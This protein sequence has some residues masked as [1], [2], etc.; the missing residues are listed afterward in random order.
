MI[1]SGYR[2]YINT[3]HANFLAPSTAS[4]EPVG[5]TFNTLDAALIAGCASYGISKYLIT[6]HAAPIVVPR[7]HA[8]SG[9]V[10]P[11]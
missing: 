7:A 2:V 5:P 1:N 11:C 8:P 9:G 10:M 4:W 3:L 6:W